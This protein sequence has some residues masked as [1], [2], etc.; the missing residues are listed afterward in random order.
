MLPVSLFLEYHH[1]SNIPISEISEY[2]KICISQI[3]KFPKNDF[4]VCIIV[5]LFLFLHQKKSE[6][7]KEKK[8]C[9]CPE[10]AVRLHTDCSRSNVRR[11][12][13]YSRTS[14]QGFSADSFCDLS[15]HYRNRSS[16]SFKIIFF[17]IG[18]LI[19]FERPSA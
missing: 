13:N 15:G 8:I 19:I 3:L 2:V 16:V 7:C 9:E 17:S 18:L 6:I 10:C 11:R 4:N 1:I 5:G 14:R 12:C